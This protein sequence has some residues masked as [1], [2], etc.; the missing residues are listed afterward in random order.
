MQRLVIALILTLAGSIAGAQAQEAGSQAIRAVIEQQ[1]EAFQRDDGA[2]AFS[3][4]APIIKRKFGSP[5]VFMQMVRQGYDPV[6]R[7]TSREFRQTTVMADR[8]VQEVLLVD[9]AG[10]AW[11]ARYFM[12]RQADGTWQI[13]GVRLEELPE[14]SV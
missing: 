5:E 3:F 2:G 7:P 12:E 10:K 6:Y 1:L 13:A 8:A 4:A 11:L 14:V 9:R